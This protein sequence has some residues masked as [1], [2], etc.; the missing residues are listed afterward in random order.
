MNPKLVQTHK[1]ES[2][3]GFNWKVQPIPDY[4]PIVIISGAHSIH[5]QSI[6]EQNKK[7]GR[8]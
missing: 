6:V 1:F 8:A 7:G 5:S 4:A 3:L 2:T